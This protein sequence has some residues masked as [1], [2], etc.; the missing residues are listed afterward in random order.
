M[1]P[2]ARL[3]VRLALG[4]LADAVLPRPEEARAAGVRTWQGGQGHTSR[5]TGASLPAA[6]L[7]CATDLVFHVLRAPHADPESARGA[8]LLRAAP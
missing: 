5:G 4:A 8:T 3:G 7:D 1:G 6:R 2:A